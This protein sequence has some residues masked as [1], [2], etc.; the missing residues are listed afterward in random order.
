MTFL[1][2]IEGNIGSGKSTF[3]KN[4]GL[5]Y[6]RSF[7]KQNLD[8][9]IVQEPV[10]Q[11]VKTYDSD[12]KNILEKFYENIDRW[13]FTFQMNSFISRT[14]TIQD[15]LEKETPNATGFDKEYPMRKALFVERSVFTDKNVFAKNCF[16]S[17]KMTKMEYDIYCNWNK[18]LSEKFELSPSAYIYL[19]CDPKVNNERIIKRARSE[20]ESIPIEYLTQIHNKHED[21]MYHEME[22]GVPVL[23]IDA[24][25][26]FTKEEKMDELYQKVYNFVENLK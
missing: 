25:E 10:D 23:T 1:I 13:S 26:D 4:L 2:Y 15:E 7:L 14:K 12:G 11:W 22:K 3:A 17:N 18:W 8:A 21:W 6:L 9:R 20:E 16:E 24:T 19:K 5:K